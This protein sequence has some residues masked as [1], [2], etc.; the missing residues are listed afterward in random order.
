MSFDP[1]IVTSVQVLSSENKGSG[2]FRGSPI[3]VKYSL[4][5]DGYFP[6]ILEAV[7]YV[8]HNC[9]IQIPAAAKS[10]LQK[11]CTMH[12]YHHARRS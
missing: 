5:I 8:S 10:I 3:S 2:F 6:A 1:R 12:T 4:H 11:S 9:F 7:F